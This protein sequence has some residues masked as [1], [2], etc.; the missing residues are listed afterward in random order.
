MN[1]SKMNGSL[2]IGKYGDCIII[3]DSSWKKIIYEM[4]DPPIQYVIKKG[5]IVYNKE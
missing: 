3:D 1:R 2:E 5:K 4:I